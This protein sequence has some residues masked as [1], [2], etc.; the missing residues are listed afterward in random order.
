MRRQNLVPDVN[1]RAKLPLRAERLSFGATTAPARP[2]ADTMTAPAVDLYLAFG[3]C[4]GEKPLPAQR[5]NDAVNE[6]SIS[7][8]DRYDPELLEQRSVSPTELCLAA[9]ARNGTTTPSSSNSSSRLCSDGSFVVGRNDCSKLAARN[10]AAENLPAAAQGSQRRYVIVA[11]APRVPTSLDAV[12]WSSGL[13][14]G[15]GKI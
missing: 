4:S 1:P 14:I 8:L 10:V 9:P 11:V 2:S 15:W 5:A 12:A 6:G 7:A 3:I 13:F